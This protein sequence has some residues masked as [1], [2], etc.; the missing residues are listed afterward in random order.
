[1]VLTEAGFGIS[2]GADDPGVKI[3]AAI[4]EI[5]DFAR[6]RVEQERVDREVAAQGIFAGVSLEAHGLGMT[7]VEILEIAAESG[8]FDVGVFVVNENDSE[9]RAYA[10]G[11]GE[12]A[13]KFIGP[14]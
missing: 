3:G 6:E 12:E 5:E 9:V 14:G 8:D 13:Q 11:A 10:I 4:G 7:T 1:V 2:D